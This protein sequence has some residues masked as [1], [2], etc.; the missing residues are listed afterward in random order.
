MGVIYRARQRHSKRIVALKRV[1]SYHGDSRETLE[2]FRREA[3]AAASLDHPNILPIYEVGEAE[4]LP[5]FTMKYATGGTLQ[6]AAP[7]LRDD[8]P[9]C[10]RL[11]AKVT[12]AVAY[13]HREG[14]LHRDLKPGNILLD[15]R[16]EPMVSDFGLA[17]WIDATSD[18]TRSLAIF[19]TPGFI[20]PEQASGD[21]NALTPAADVYSLGAILFDLLSGR[22]PF[23]GEHALAVIQQAAE[24]PAPKLRALNHSLGKDLETICS[25]CLER[26]P[27]MRYQ[28]ASDL[29]EDLERWLEGRPIMA[30][31]VFPAVKAWRWSKRNPLLAVTAAVCML[32]AGMAILRQIHNLRLERQIAAQSALQHSV[33]INA[34]LDIDSVQPSTAWTRDFAG[35]LDRDFERLGPHL[36]RFESATSAP[37]RSLLSG[38]IRTVDQKLRISAQVQNASTGAP[39][40]NKIVEVNKATAPAE[41]AQLF[42]RELSSLLSAADLSTMATRISDPGLLDEEAHNFIQSGVEL[43]QRRDG[44]DLE[45]A[46]SCFQHALELQPTSS[47]AHAGLAKV[48]SFKAALLSTREPLGKALLEARKAIELNPDSSEAHLALAGVFYH[49]GKMHEALDE[50]LRALEQ[51]PFSRESSG[52]LPT[53]YKAVGRPD[54]ALAWLFATQ[55]TEYRPTPGVGDCWALL[56]CDDK[57][58]RIY[59]YYSRLHPEQPEGWMGLCRLRLLNGKID[60]ARDVYRKEQKGYSYFAYAKQMAAEVEF[61]GRNFTEAEALYAELADS[62]S[63]GGGEFYGSVTYPSALG[64]LRLLRHDTRGGLLLDRAWENEAAILRETP[65]LPSALYRMA[66]IEACLGKTESALQHLRTAYEAGWIDYRSMQLDP[67]FDSL[68]AQDSFT[69]ITHLMSDRVAFLREA[70]LSALEPQNKTGKEY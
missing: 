4:D 35:Y 16:G 60:E 34:F 55:K 6:Q 44:I 70:A 3:E 13:A 48:W 51:S 67:R 29:A 22:P 65:E 56:L 30:R 45:R 15:G 9:E 52:L 58:E 47:A 2:R 61:F 7:A 38:T 18:L 24:K 19:G 10:V 12:R 39:L 42:A 5:F 11:I 50:N 64:Y 54:K 40:L 25:K 68:R 17:K 66:A 32:A 43:S 49:I 69:E 14:I 20:A 28:S 37:V 26:E 57:A 36:V 41:A 46:I 31:P 33:Q 21:R 1:L 62:N 8:P 53:I 63:D 59:Q 23:L 27:Q